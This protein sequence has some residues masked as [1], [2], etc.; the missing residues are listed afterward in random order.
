LEWRRKTQGG[1]AMRE[2]TE[3]KNTFFDTNEGGPCP[4]EKVRVFSS[5][6]EPQS[7]GGKR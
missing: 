6:L 4:G 1:E 7:V 3:T 5:V 2:R